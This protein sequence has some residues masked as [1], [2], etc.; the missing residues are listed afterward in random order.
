MD[1]SDFVQ[2]SLLQEVGRYKY[3]HVIVTSQHLCK[4]FSM[5]QKNYSNQKVTKVLPF[6]A[7]EL[8]P[9]YSMEIVKIA[10]L[11]EMALSRLLLAAW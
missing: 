6:V 3:F 4:Q 2:V 7:V 10:L 8:I 11:E 1:W 5:I 9:I